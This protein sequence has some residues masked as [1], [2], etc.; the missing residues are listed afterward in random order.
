MK[1]NAILLR[2]QTLKFLIPLFFL[3][4]LGG[5]L[6]FAQKKDTTKRDTT[7]IIQV[8]PNPPGNNQQFP[9][10][11]VISPSPEAASLGRYGEIPVSLSTG[12]ASF[13]I[14]IYEVVSGT[15]KVPVK[16]SYHSSGVKVND[17]A[18]SVGI[19]WSLQGGG[20]VTRVVKGGLWDDCSLGILHQTIPEQTDVANFFCFIGN[21]NTSIDFVDGMPDDFFY[22]FN[23][24]SGKFIYNTRNTSNQNITPIPVT[25][26]HSKLKI[27]WVN[28]L[29]F[30]ITDT[31]GTLY[32]FENIESTILT[33][34]PNARNN[35]CGTSYAS[36]WYLTKIVSANRVDTIRFNYTT[37][38]SLETGDIW[39]TTLNK[40]VNEFGHSFFSYQYAFQRTNTQSILLQEI[41]YKNGKVGFTYAHDRQDLSDTDASRLTTITIYKKDSVGTAT[42]LKHFSLNHSYFNCSDGYTQVDNPT[43]STFYHTNSPLLKRLR[44]NSVTEVSADNQTLPPYQ[45]SYYEDHPLP[46]YASLAQDYWGYSN[47]AITN[48]NLLLWNTDPT[49]LVEP[50]TTYGANCHFNFSYAVSG[51]LKKIIYPTGG[52]TTL[53]YEPQMLSDSTK[54]GGIR[55]KKVISSDYD[56]TQIQHIRYNYTQPYFTNSAFSGEITDE[57]YVFTTQVWTDI[58]GAG[59]CNQWST[60][61]Y[62]TYPEKVTFSLGSAASFVAY[63]EV[64]EYH[65]DTTG[66]DN[67][68]NR[69]GKIKYIYTTSSDLI[70]SNFPLELIFTDWKRGLLL[71]KK[72]YSVLPDSSEIK[73][74][75]EQHTYQEYVQSYKSRGYV[76]RLS[77]NHDTYQAACPTNLTIYCSKYSSGNEYVFQEINQQS[78]ILLPTKL[79]T[80][81]YDQN[82]AN[83]VIDSLLYE[84]NTSYLQLIK[85]TTTNS[86][87]SIYESINRYPYDFSGTAVYDT[88]I[89]RHIF[90]PIVETELKKDGTS[91]RKVRTN[92]KHWYTSTPYGGVNGFCAPLSVEKQEYGGAMETEVVMGETLSTPT[93]NGYDTRGRPILYTER[94]GLTTQLEW[95]N[96]TGKKDLVKKKISHNLTTAFDYESILGIKKITAPNNLKSTFFYD[97][98]GRLS[99]TQDHDNNKLAEYQYVYGTPNQVITKQYRATVTGNVVANTDP[100]YNFIHR[101]FDGLGRPLQEVGEGFSPQGKDIV[102]SSQ[103]YDFFGRAN[104][105]VAIFP[106]DTTTGAYV[107]NGISL[108]QRFYKDSSPASTSLYEKSSLNR[109]RSTLGLGN[110][111]QLAN[112]KTYYFDETAGTDVRKYTIDGSGNIT[113]SGTYPANSLYK[114]RVIDEQGNTTIE[115][116]DRQRQVV[117]KQQQNGSDWLTTY[118]LYDGLGRVVAILQP[119]VYALSTS[120]LQ[121]S[122]AW[123]NGVFFYK[124]DTRGRVIEKHIPNGGFTYIVYDKADRIVL[125]QDAYQQT[126]NRWTF[127]KYDKLSREVLSGEL[128]NTNSRS[129]FQSLFNSQTTISETFDSTLTSQLFYTNTS[130]PVSID[131]SNVMLVHY[132]D[133]YSGWRENSFTPF[134]SYYINSKGLLTGINRR[135]THNRMWLTEV[136]YHNTKN[137]VTEIRKNNITDYVEQN[138][139]NYT[140]LGGLYSNQRRYSSSIYYSSSYTRDRVERITGYYLFLS[141]PSTSFELDAIYLYNEIG[142]LAT[143]KLEPNRQYQRTSAGQNYITRP[144]ALDEANIQDIANKAV[145]ISP[146]FVA[147]ST[148]ETYVAQIDTTSG[149]GFVDALQTINYNYHIRGQ[150]NCINCLN[151]E[152]YPNPKENDF[153]SMKLNFEEDQRYFD[154]NISQ[155]TWKTPI[156]PKKQQYKY[157]YDG[158]SRLIKSTYSGGT[159]GTNFSLD[160]LRYDRNGN[161][162][163]LKRRTIDNLSYSYTGNQLLSVTDNGGTS[164][165]F[166][167][168]N[169]SSNDYEYWANGALKKDKNKGIDSII[170]HSYLKKVSR[171]KFSNGNWINFYYD[172]TG[173]L[174][175]RTLSNGD[176]WFYNDD[177]I[178]KNGKVYQ[179]NHDEGRVIYDSTAQKWLKEFDY[180]DIWG[181]LRVSFR[182]SLA[183]PVS[184]VY[185]PPV[186]TQVNDYD[187]F[188]LEIGNG[189]AGKKVNNFKYQNQERINDFA[190][191]IDFF[192]FR[193]SDYQIGRFWQVDPL[194]SDY[195]HNS[196]YA[197]QE[198]KFGLGFELEGA[199]VSPFEMHQSRQQIERNKST[200]TPQEAQRYENNGRAVGTLAVGGM[201]VAGIV[202]ATAPGLAMWALANPIAATE[203]GGAI[204]GGTAGAMGYDGNDIVPATYSDDAGLRVGQGANKLLNG[205]DEA[206]NAGKNVL[207]HYTNEKGMK[208][209]IESGELKPSLKA[210]NA[211]DVR[212]GDG[213]Y[214]TDIIPNTKTSGQLAR[215]FLKVPNK[216]KYTHYVGIDVSGLSTTMGRDAVYVVPNTSPLN[217]TNRIVSY[218][219]NK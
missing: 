188:G 59:N 119:E 145:T 98:F 194:A 105:S 6:S 150:I 26:P 219:K 163:Q 20:A 30:L 103:S 138:R 58:G 76:A 218:G 106:A 33:Q 172:A 49:L 207:Y 35:P 192:K 75:E 88:M 67:T 159:A 78:S 82:G 91:L 32:A 93:Q 184:G 157:Q 161:I 95:W 104:S 79:K 154:G 216:Y 114:K 169:T 5:H 101:Y 22:N 80:L 201:L 185:K 12:T 39:S 107:S 41:N 128:S 74:L 205:T 183:N 25:Y 109:V 31:D 110:I 50:S 44:L 141:L 1:N 196:V 34:S 125:S 65:Y 4:A 115:I 143:K 134:D 92:Y 16:L 136:L 86:N 151:K 7:T 181:N 51:A 191:G 174:L 53:Y 100:N 215:Q 19:G 13:D 121:N 116:L 166:N 142:Q 180:R 42:E 189:Y 3:F 173:A 186:L 123:D 24:L 28:Q 27:D 199:E 111:W 77:I 195:P 55:I 99:S 133:N 83:P 15:L 187:A 122:T 149:S 193:P 144:P 108:A 139:K 208:G 155:Q 46:I 48:R 214:L 124:Y 17:I 56:N 217:I 72:T 117:Q 71:N 52:Y 162:L 120:I 210:N 73:I 131:S 212:Y 132:Y 179:I 90:S 209:I 202:G 45:L 89:T 177:L 18:S 203:T 140:F 63:E 57:T 126:L 165:G 178:I 96:H 10:L 190:V 206:T 164:A 23:G 211:K 11:N 129:T 204:L 97:S 14:P 167:D 29:N 148:F 160:T 113:L 171:V 54:G 135:Y 38:V 198:N 168:G 175:K 197:L 43:Y 69:L 36:A 9:F 87:G 2:R 68:A 61:P 37:A 200:M 153:F 60:L 170:Y 182:D 62:T 152:V 213:Q 85:T 94:S 118:S 130:F 21:L 146:G 102:F 127:Q 137:R 147:D 8:L 47:G 81:T 112:K 176:E 66:K 64:E 70:S 158:I 156:V 84:Y 40:K